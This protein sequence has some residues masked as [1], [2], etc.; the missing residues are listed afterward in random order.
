MTENQNQLMHP[1]MTSGSYAT[2]VFNALGQEDYA[3]LLS[4]LPDAFYRLDHWAQEP[5][6]RQ[7]FARVSQGERDLACLAAVMEV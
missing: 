5:I 3:E 7:I 2:F 6:W 4:Q 1:L